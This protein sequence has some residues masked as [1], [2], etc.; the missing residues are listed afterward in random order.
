MN[1]PQEI[2]NR[3]KVQT[4]IANKSVKILLETCE[5]NKNFVNKIASGTDVGYQSIVKIADYLD[6]SVDYL[7]GRDIKKGAPDSIRDAIIARV[8]SLPDDRLDRLL[9]FLEGLTAE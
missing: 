9:G 5:L 7:L 3:I 8:N 4:K 1:N 2:A 6:C